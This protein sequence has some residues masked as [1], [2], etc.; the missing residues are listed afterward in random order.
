MKGTLLMKLLPPTLG[1][2]IRGNPDF[3]TYDQKLTYIKTAVEFAQSD[4]RY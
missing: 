2:T 1:V 3:Q 4:L